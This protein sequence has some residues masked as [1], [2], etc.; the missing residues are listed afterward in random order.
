M[1]SAA[2]LTRQILG[3]ARSGKYEV[4]TTDINR[5]VNRSSE[6]FGRTKKEITIHKHFQDEIWL[7]DVDRGQIE[8]VLLNLYINA[9]QAMPSGGNLY[10]R[11]KMSSSMKNSPNRTVFRLAGA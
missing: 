6:M 7:A 4:K 3:F 8:Q 9:W 1:K 10:M 5:L 11:L 2:D